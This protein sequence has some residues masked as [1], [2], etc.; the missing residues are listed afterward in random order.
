MVERI[1]PKYFTYENEL[2]VG[3]V[4]PTNFTRFN[5]I[6]ISTDKNAK[7]IRPILVAYSLYEFLTLHDI[8]LGETKCQ[9][10]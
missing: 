6:N 10:F 3:F 4:G 1:D 5:H 9:N 2:P 8:I 7:T